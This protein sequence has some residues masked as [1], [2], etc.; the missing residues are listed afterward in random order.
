MSTEAFDAN[1]DHRISRAE[2]ASLVRTFHSRAEAGEHRS[3]TFNRGAFERLLDQPGAAGIRVYRARHEDGS[4]TLV[5]VAVDATGQDL[6][7]LDAVFIQKGTDC[8]PYCV[9]QAWF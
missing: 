6:A 7:T 1:R 4:P 3:S 8:P 9:S 2:A 5:M